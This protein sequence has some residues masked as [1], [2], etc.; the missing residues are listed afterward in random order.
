VG[1][2]D[3][4]AQR[5]ALLE[6]RLENSARI[7]R[8]QRPGFCEERIPVGWR[9]LVS[10]KLKLGKVWGQISLAGLVNRYDHASFQD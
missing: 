2:F 10:L 9:R 6:Q 1:E 7:T 4:L 8:K 3:L 5:P